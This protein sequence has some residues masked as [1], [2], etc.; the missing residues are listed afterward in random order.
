MKFKQILLVLAEILAILT[1]SIYLYTQSK[2]NFIKEKVVSLHPEITRVSKTAALG[3]WGEFYS[4]FV[5]EVEADG[6]H[7]RLWTDG[8][9][10][11]DPFGEWERI[12]TSKL[13]GK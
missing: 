7:Y 4:E 8:E 6:V 10:N 3:S 5:L 2:L 12:G 1:A 9:G 13:K 11:P